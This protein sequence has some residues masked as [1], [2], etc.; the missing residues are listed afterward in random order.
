[1]SFNVYLIICIILFFAFQSF[2]HRCVYLIVGAVGIIWCILWNVLVYNTP[3]NH[4]RITDREKRYIELSIGS[5]SADRKASIL[6]FI[7]IFK[8]RA[9]HRKRELIDY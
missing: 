9:G 1:M 2:K 4:P 6:S 8:P 5:S 7:S 3:A